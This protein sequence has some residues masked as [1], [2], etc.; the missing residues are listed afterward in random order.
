MGSTEASLPLSGGQ[1]APRLGARPAL[2]NRLI[3]T[4][5]TDR[6]TLSCLPG[7]LC[8]AGSIEQCSHG[9][10]LR[11]SRPQATHCQQ[12][13]PTSWVYRNPQE[14]PG[15][16]CQVL[17]M[18]V[19]AHICI[20]GNRPLISPQPL[21][22]CSWDDTCYGRC[23]GGLP[24]AVRAFHTDCKSQGTSVEISTLCCSSHRIQTQHYCSA[25]S[26]PQGHLK[27]SSQEGT[28]VVS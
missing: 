15:P 26:C 1:V 2:F 27:M 13:P 10:Q 4:P 7:Q 9:A 23:Q 20:H 18:C 19:R 22:A 11:S 12:R 8:T 16:S 25:Q 24:G 3:P 5:N 28:G 6:R 17:C 21:C 14:A